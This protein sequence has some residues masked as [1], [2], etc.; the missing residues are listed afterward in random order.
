MRGVVRTKM[1]VAVKGLQEFEAVSFK[2]SPPKTFS[3]GTAGFR[4]K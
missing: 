2:E 1:D 4:E 3:Y